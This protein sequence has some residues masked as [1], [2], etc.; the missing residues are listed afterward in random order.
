MSNSIGEAKLYQRMLDEAYKLSAKSSILDVNPARIR[1]SDMAGTFYI[2][3]LTLVG[4]GDY[5]TSTGYPEGDV[6]LDWV[7][8][9]YAED[10]GR[11][12][13]VDTVENA[14]AAMMAF[15]D[16]ERTF[17]NQYET[18][19]IDAYRF[20]KIATDAGTDATGTLDTAA[21][22]CSALNVALGVLSDAEVPDSE[23]IL[24]IRSGLRRLVTT[25]AKTNATTDAF[26]LCTTVEVPKGR[27]YTVCTTNAGATGSA[28]GYVNAG[29]EINFILMDKGAAFADAKHQSLR[30]FSPN[31][32]GGYPMWQDGENWVQQFRLKHDCWIYSNRETGVYVHTK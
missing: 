20:A 31:G 30:T 25:D 27:F 29:A 1:E 16:L 4:L 14:E 28:G 12:F 22:V 17:I 23:L 3:K 19:E 10:R 6:V 8:Y 21:K 9:T 7:A 2:P 11:Q 32:E 24:F 5:S 18:P 26:D 13:R 15:G